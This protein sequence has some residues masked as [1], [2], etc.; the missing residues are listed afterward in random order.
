MM[1]GLKA[2]IAG[3]AGI[4]AIALGGCNTT[5]LVFV[6]S[7]TGGV[8]ADTTTQQLSIG[9]D[10]TE[11]YIGPRFPNGQVVPAMASFDGTGSVSSPKG[12]DLFATGDAAVII[13]NN[14]L[15]DTAYVPPEAPADAA[16]AVERVFVGTATNIGLKVGF[17][18]TSAVAVNLGYRRAVIGIVSPGVA[19][20]ATDKTRYIYPSVIASSD[21]RGLISTPTE[22]KGRV[23]QFILIGRAAEVAASSDKFGIRSG[24]EDDAE[25]SFT[26]AAWVANTESESK[27]ALAF[28]ACYDKVIKDAP[29][30]RPEIWATVASARLYTGAPDQAAI[31]EDL[32][33]ITD[34]A[35]ADRDFREN[36]LFT[37]GVSGRAERLAALTKIYCE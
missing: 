33:A 10:R 36:F 17:S 6:T 1:T 9:F 28:L 23:N 34:M 26:S 22:T 25:A 20:D 8:V 29:Q 16:P 14:G 30:K 4:A 12:R 24:F 27:A 19:R 2:L 13:A 5:D 11:G 3:A 35:E 21:A 32:T 37:S 15:P 7:T 31:V 18:G